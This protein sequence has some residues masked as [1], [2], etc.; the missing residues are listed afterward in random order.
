MEPHRLI[1]LGAGFSAPAG[2][3]LNNQLMPLLLEE[4][5]RIPDGARFRATRDVNNFCEY[6]SLRTG[7]KP[8]PESIN[9]EEFMTFL[10]LEHHLGLRGSDTWSA[11]GNETQIYVRF[12]I[13]RLLFGYQ[14]KM[15]DKQWDLYTAFVSRL[16]PGDVILTFNYDTIVESACDRARVKYRLCSNRYEEV[17]R[18]GSG[19]RRNLEDEVIICK[20]HGSIDW[21]SRERFDR[22]MAR[23]RRNPLNPRPRHSVFE[24]EGDFEVTPLVEQPYPSNDP[25]FHIYRARNLAPLFSDPDAVSPTP[26]LIAPSH[27]KIV[28]LNPLLGFWYDFNSMGVSKSQMIVIGFS[29]PIQDEYAMAPVVK[30]IANFQRHN[31]ASDLFGT[32][33]LKIVDYQPSEE[34]QQAFRDSKPFI[35]WPHTDCFWDGLSADIINRVLESSTYR[36]THNRPAMTSS[37]ATEQ[38][39]PYDKVFPNVS[40]SGDMVGQCTLNWGTTQGLD[41]FATDCGIDLSKWC[42]IA[43]NVVSDKDGVSVSV[44]AASIEEYNQVDAPFINMV[45]HQDDG[46][47]Y[48]HELQVPHVPTDL[49]S[50]HGQVAASLIRSDMGAVEELRRVVTAA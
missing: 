32:T 15:T 50:R 48:V 7:T 42:P 41:R 8:A 31:D 2:L 13:A 45:A 44:L 18:G 20:L 12:L 17:H 46:V 9:V 14:A 21:F 6:R 27:S 1:I 24:N 47:V 29:F 36:G 33:R 43:V 5:E 37:D 28:Y 30:A 11:E 38:N 26:L 19:F 40:A 22:D 34:S 35:D 25:F 39:R 3:P 49:I 16:R 23:Y 4:F 10:D